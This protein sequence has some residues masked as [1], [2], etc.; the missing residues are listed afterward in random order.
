VRITNKLIVD[1]FL[2]NLQNIKGNLLRK[3]IEA[4]TQKKI[5]APSDSP[6]E[7]LR[8]LN[9]RA[10]IARN[11]KFQSN[12]GSAYGWLTENE[13]VLSA[14]GSLLGEEAEE[15]VLK[16]MDGSYS[17][18]ERLILANEVDQMLAE[19]LGMAN[20]SYGGK[21]LF[22]GYKTKTSPFEEVD[23][24]VSNVDPLPSDMVNSL[25]TGSPFGDL[26]ELDSGIYT[27]SL[28]YELSGQTTLTIRDAEG[29]VVLLDSDG[30]DGS[31][32]Q[33]GSNVLADSLTIN[34]SGDDVLD[35]GRG[36][37]LTLVGSGSFPAN[38]TVRSFQV[39]Y[40]KGGSVVYLGDDGSI[41]TTIGP[42]T[43][44]PINVL[45]DA[46]FTGIQEVL[47][48]DRINRASGSPIT[49]STTWDSID[50]ALVQI[51]DTITIGGTDH[52]GRS[53]AGYARVGGESVRLDQSGQGAAER[54]L[55][56]TLNGGATESITISANNFASLGDLVSDVNAQIAASPTLNGNVVAVASGDGLEFQTMATGSS[57]S[58]A[59]FGDVQGT[60]GFGT[61]PVF[62]SGRDL[63]YQISDPTT[64]TVQGL[65]DT[66]EAAYGGRVTAAVDKDGRIVVTDHLS[67][68]S[69]LS[70]TLAYTGGGALDLGS[71]VQSRKGTNVDLFNVL[72]GLSAALREN[73]VNGIG[74]VGDWSVT[75]D[76]QKTVGG[77]YTGTA[78]DTWLFRVDSTGGQIGVTAGL[79]IEVIDQ[80]SG[81]L[82]KTLD[83][84]STYTPGTALDVAQGVT[85]SLGD[86]DTLVGGETFTLGLKGKAVGSYL[87]QIRGS[88]L[89]LG[90]AGS[91]GWRTTF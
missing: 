27:V 91:P 62:D 90:W 88:K 66:I 10:Y 37:K 35:T 57:E 44:V 22:G 17:F 43:T 40:V 68:T 46:I 65:L 36:L 86:T 5:Q 48:G 2:Q 32:V 64:D 45:G 81:R 24:S 12:A 19:L 20:A 79:T 53:L 75:F 23:R 73:N 59:V 11:E 38:D 33:G 25:Q 39:S 56:V 4:S 71:M 42:D 82:I 58:I 41:D 13:S 15:I 61:N 29:N 8:A 83:V 80:S 28:S 72:D 84:G 1:N 9:W 54:T 52:S 31:S 60:L 30:Q 67:G 85:V 14:L 16:G 50:G 87:E 55:Y 89:A 3:Q 76:A 74:T 70:L 34:A 6:L 21:Y 51:G 7:A 77:E 78:G 69:H 18:Q 26:R 47:L 63:T 49:A